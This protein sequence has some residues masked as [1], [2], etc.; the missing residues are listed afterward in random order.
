MEVLQVISNIKKQKS[1]ALQGYTSQSASQFQ[2]HNQSMP[3]NSQPQTFPQPPQQCFTTPMN[4]SSYS[5][6]PHFQP[7]DP[8]SLLS[9]YSQHTLP[10]QPL[11]PRQNHPTFT[12]TYSNPPQ[13]PP[14]NPTTT[15]L[16]SSQNDPS[17]SPSQPR[18][19][20]KTFTTLNSYHP[21]PPTLPPYN[22]PSAPSLS[23]Q[24]DLPTSP[25]S[26]MNDKGFRAA[27]HYE[28]FSDCLE[29]DDCERSSS[30][31]SPNSSIMDDN[32]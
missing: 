16:L 3:Y 8:P 9:V 18:E 31:D 30:V 26:S 29:E 25:A 11:Q 13:P 15:P 7:Y 6:R 27:D 2:Q 19:N 21:Q 5:H 1:A 22:P 23:S 20:H 10:T 24:N 4:N 17:T 14:F 12:T 32:F 28:N